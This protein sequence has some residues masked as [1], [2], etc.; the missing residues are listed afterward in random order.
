MVPLHQA[1]PGKQPLSVQLP[2][3]DADDSS[4]GG[5]QSPRAE[6]GSLIRMMLQLLPPLI[7]FAVANRKLAVT[8][9]YCS[10]ITHLL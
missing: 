4:T 10:L 9:Q 3:E 6:S 7:R 1:Q 8:A 5:G 2:H